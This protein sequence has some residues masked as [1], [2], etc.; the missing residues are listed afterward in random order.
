MSYD[1]YLSS[2]PLIRSI[3]LNIYYTY[4]LHILCI[5]FNDFKPLHSRLKVALQISISISLIF[6]RIAGQSQ[7]RIYAAI[8]SQV[9]IRTSFI[10]A[11]LLITLFCENN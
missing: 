9:Y 4:I 2:F 6:Q 10:P 7:S 1:S 3:L 8:F 5:N 11:L